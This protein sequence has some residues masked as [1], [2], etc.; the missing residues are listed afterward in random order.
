MKD[1]YLG[2]NTIIRFEMLY[3]EKC[4]F[5]KYIYINKSR[6]YS[7]KRKASDYIFIKLNNR[8][9]DHKFG[10]LKIIYIYDT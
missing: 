6:K 3:I 5:Q 7:E 1:K 8:F 9:F 10:L 4:Q 2:K